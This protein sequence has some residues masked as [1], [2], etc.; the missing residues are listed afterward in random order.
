MEQD[1]RKNYLWVIFKFGIVVAVAMVVIYGLE[2]YGRREIYREAAEI[3]KDAELM[4]Q[5]EQK[6][7]MSD[8]YGGRTPQ[9]TLQMY[10]SAV[11]KGDYELASK[12]FVEKARDKELDSLKNSPI[13]N[14]INI[15][16]M[17]KQSIFTDDG[18]TWDRKEYGVSR[19]IFVGFILYPN[20]IWKIT[21]I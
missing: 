18:Y 5:E 2:A 15:N 10:I 14:V 11:E 8:T 1:K 7:L 21:E 9:E 3:E 17:L 20:G 4:R 19:P 16:D 12:Y 6:K 13:N